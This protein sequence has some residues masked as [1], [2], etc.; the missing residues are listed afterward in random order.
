M[1]YIRRYGCFA[2]NYFYHP[3]VDQDSY[4][5]SLSDA[6]PQQRTNNKESPVRAKVNL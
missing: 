4:F 3:V 6:H 1:L 2:T 5:S